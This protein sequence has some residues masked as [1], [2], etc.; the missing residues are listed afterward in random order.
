MSLHTKT[1]LR[2]EMN[3]LIKECDCETCRDSLYKMARYIMIK[4]KFTM[5]YDGVHVMILE[6]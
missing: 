4:H 2:A 5:K 6:D 1:E 3:D